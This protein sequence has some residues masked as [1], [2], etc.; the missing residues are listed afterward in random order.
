[1]FPLIAYAA[2]KMKYLTNTGASQ[3]GQDKNI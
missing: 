3:F 1:M 2:Y